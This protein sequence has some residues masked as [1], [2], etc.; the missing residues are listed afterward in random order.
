[1][2]VKE[3]LM[4]L[5]GIAKP[6]FVNAS[7]RIRK[8]LSTR[9]ASQDRNAMVVERLT[10]RR[11]MP[12]ILTLLRKLFSTLEI[13]EPTFK[14]VVLLYRLAKPRDGDPAGPSGSRSGSFSSLST[15]SPWLISR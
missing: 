7:S 6:V 9:E 13:Q 10:L 11:L 8:S 1:M 12:N 5:M 3:P 4:K 2:L 14:E 15:T